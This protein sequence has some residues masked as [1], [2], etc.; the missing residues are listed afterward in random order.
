MVGCMKAFYNKYFPANVIVARKVEMSKFSQNKKESLPQ[1]W[2][3]FSNM[4]RKCPSH[5]FADH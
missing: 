4:K 5:G 2:G 1:A 3:R